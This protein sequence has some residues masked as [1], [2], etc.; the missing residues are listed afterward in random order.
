MFHTV[1][2]CEDGVSEDYFQ[3][4]EELLA[5]IASFTSFGKTELKVA[6]CVTNPQPPSFKFDPPLTKGRSTFQCSAVV[7]LWL[8]LP[9]YLQRFIV[10]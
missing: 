10:P 6:V 2:S 5:L 4:V 8:M 7:I 3:P 1:P 9:N